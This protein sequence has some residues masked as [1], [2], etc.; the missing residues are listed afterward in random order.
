MTTQTPTTFQ[1][2]KKSLYYCYQ[3]TNDDTLVVVGSWGF[4]TATEARVWGS[5]HNAYHTI[6]GAHIL[7]YTD[8]NR[9]ISKRDP[10]F[11]LI[12]KQG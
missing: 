9:P 3:R 12:R 7:H 8:P 5:Q 4:R 6:K 10:L 11:T 2:I 1:P